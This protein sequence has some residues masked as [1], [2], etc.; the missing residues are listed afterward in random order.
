MSTVNVQELHE[1][2]TLVDQIVDDI[3]AGRVTANPLKPDTKTV[4]EIDATT[5]SVK[6]TATEL[7]EEAAMEETILETPVTAEETKTAPV[8]TETTTTNEG[9][10]AIGV[11]KL[12]GKDGEL[13]FVPNTKGTA[14]GV[15]GGRAGKNLVAVTA[16]DGFIV[17]FTSPAAAAHHTGLN[18]TTMRKW[19]DENKVDTFNNTWSYCEL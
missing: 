7:G 18:P 11:V 10:Q 1:F 15:P 16:E 6:E 14:Y 3:E 12:A 2:N 17:Y 9:T 19:A 13:P 5:I 8:E 4:A